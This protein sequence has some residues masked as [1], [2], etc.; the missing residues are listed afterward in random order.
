MDEV[1][2]VLNQLSKLKTAQGNNYYLKL[3][4]RL[5]KQERISVF[6]TCMESNSLAKHA[7]KIQGTFFEGAKGGFEENIGGNG[8]MSRKK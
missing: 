7:F 2:E 4:N 1:Q 3:V 5:N 8:S 6:H